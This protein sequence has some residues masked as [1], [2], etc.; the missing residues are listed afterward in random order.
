MAFLVEQAGGL[1][2]TGKTR[3]MDLIPQSVHQRV[4]IILGSREDV[5][6]CRK[7]YEASTDEKL[8]KR[9]LER[10]S[11]GQAVSDVSGGGAGRVALDTSG[12]GRVDKLEE[13]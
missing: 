2:L 1:A 4:P 11:P 12:D 7:Y 5:L 3:V 8:A 10:L 13:V 9:C 6:E